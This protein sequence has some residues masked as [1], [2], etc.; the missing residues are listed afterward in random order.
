M[1]REVLTPSRL[2]S[3][4]VFNPEFVRGVLAA[5]PHQRLRWHYFM[6]WQ[7]IGTE[8]WRETFVEGRASAQELGVNAR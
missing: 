2:Q 4:G 7:M 1:A 8:L 3:G 6:L 5:K